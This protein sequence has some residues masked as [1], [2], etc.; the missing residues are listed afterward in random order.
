M[1][2]YGSKEEIK[3]PEDDLGGAPDPPGLS[4]LPPNRQISD[5]AQGDKT[6]AIVEP[7]SVAV[8]PKRAP[9]HG[10]HRDYPS[11]G[12]RPYSFQPPYPYHP[13]PSHMMQIPHVSGES[14]P[15]PHPSSAHHGGGD[16]TMELSP[17]RNMKK[18][19]AS[20][21]KTSP[22]GRHADDAT[23]KASK[24]FLTKKTLDSSRPSSEGSDLG[25]TLVDPSDADLLTDY[26]FHMLQ[27]LV[28]CRFS[29]KDRKTRGGK[30]E[31]IMIGYGGLQCIHCIDAP[32]A[33]KFFWSTVDRLANSFAEIPS[34]ILK[35]KLCP[36]DVRDALLVLKGRHHDQMQLL[37]RGSQK[38]F[39]RRMWRRLHDRDSSSSTPVRIRP[40]VSEDER[41]MDPPP[42][43]LASPDSALPAA[44]SLLA[45]GANFHLPQLQQPEVS[46]GIPEKKHVRVL[47]AIP[48]DKDWLSDMDCYVRKNIEVFTSTQ[49][50][51]KDA[52]ADRKYP[53]KVGQVG[54]RCVHCAKTPAGARSAAVSYPYSISG[55]YESVREFQRMHL[56]TCLNVPKDTKQASVKF[57]GGSA[58]LS[59]VLRRYYVQ[60][61]RALGLFDTQDDGI[62]AGKPVPMPTTRFQS[63]APASRPSA[64]DAPGTAPDDENKRK[65]SPGFDDGEGPKMK[66]FRLEDAPGTASKHHDAPAKDDVPGM[67]DAPGEIVTIYSEKKDAPGDKAADSP[68]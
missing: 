14:F 63:P 2:S 39:F 5:R 37:P 50:D 30:R 67:E 8:Q 49:Y 60:A 24:H 54:I 58:S 42:S 55:I 59:S 18:R 45:M 53:I 47:L 17:S 16:V 7:N 33:R 21:N 3:S 27:Q 26:F 57:G 65:S 10:A 23:Y 40:S 38:V 44:A 46:D 22:I 28:V 29:E 68:R 48:E 52:A 6:G 36:S 19:K 15:V 1:Q 32:S 66:R 13:Y 9:H 35:C 64:N 56:E 25:M 62:G 51:V 4:P 31:N 41:G 20:P 43:T 61:A 12:N 11:G 34:H